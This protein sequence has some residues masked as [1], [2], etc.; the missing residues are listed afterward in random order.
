MA[1]LS[2]VDA[3]SGRLLWTKELPVNRLEQVH[4]QPSGVQV[5]G[6][7]SHGCE[8][9]RLSRDYSPTGAI[10]NTT[11]LFGERDGLAEVARTPQPGVRLVSDGLGRVSAV[12][13]GSWRARV[14]TNIATTPSYT[15]WAIASLRGGVALVA[16][17]AYHGPGIG[18]YA[19]EHR[20]VDPNYAEGTQ[21]DALLAYDVR[22]GTLLWK[23]GQL[24]NPVVA[25]TDDRVYELFA[26]GRLVTR[27]LRTGRVI[28]SQQ[29]HAALAR[30]VDRGMSGESALRTIGDSAILVLDDNQGVAALGPGGS[31]RWQQRVPMDPHWS[32][33]S[34]DGS[35]LYFAIDG[36]WGF[37]ED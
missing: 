32:A 28:A 25:V 26:D 16:G 7:H 1:R 34:A 33:A 21:V 8:L 2:A 9:R 17:E 27:A 22:T 37:C 29:S 18:A 20:H 3:S 35:T 15:G 36:D 6:G 30:R 4:P 12:S 23:Q 24:G 11:Y 19:D 10:Q 14:P 5:V 13:P 31:P